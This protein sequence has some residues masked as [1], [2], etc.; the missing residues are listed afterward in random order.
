MQMQHIFSFLPIAVF[1]LG[2]KFGQNIFPQHQPIIIATAGIVIAVIILWAYAIITKKKQDKMTLYSNIFIIIFGSMTVFF[3]NPT[4]I[5][6]KITAI[7]ALFG[8]FMIY[9]VCSKNPPIAKFFAGKIMMLDKH[10]KIFSLRLAALFFALAIGNEI[11]WRNFTENTWVSYKVFY[12]PIITVV[13][14]AFQMWFL[15]KN[16]IK[17]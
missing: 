2:Y 17:K 12:A 7:N 16:S 14:F 5:K 3:N 11:V 1:F 9:N 15:M 4:F 8:L 10:W 6:I 13:F